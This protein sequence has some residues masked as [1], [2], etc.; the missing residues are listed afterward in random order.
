[1][2]F[3][4]GAVGLARQ[5]DGVLAEVGHAL[6][7]RRDRRAEP[8]AAT[9]AEEPAREVPAGDVSTD[10]APTA[11]TPRAPDPGPGPGDTAP[12]LELRDVRAGYGD[13]E[14]LHGVSL[15]VAPGQ[16][17]AVL[18]ANGAGK[19]TLCAV[20]AGLVVPTTGR[21][22]LGGVEVTDAPT[23]LRARRG[24][25]LAPEARG[26]FPGLTVEDN[27]AVRLRTP[28][29]RQAAKDRFPILGER[30][31]QVAGLLSGG[32]QQQ[33]ALAV[34][35]A[36]PPAVFVADEPTLGLAPMA[37]RTVVD[38][39]QELRDLGTAVVL[40]EEQVAAGLE[41]A[42]RV[43]LVELGTVAWEGP[44][45]E[46]DVERLTDSYFGSGGT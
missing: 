18:G 41:L 28:A 40:V 15:S 14:V 5:P 10:D 45:A 22:L 16:V 34:A 42:D 2:L 24:L 21:V 44:R 6:R 9:T 38:A 12:A 4:L 33:L 32:E 8:A 13:V 31:H 20:A 39:L 27:L 1:M 26:I 30:H 19:S 43:T 36:D 29:A 17:V 25:V 35:L 37:T 46:L 3:G 7:A 11:S 23:H